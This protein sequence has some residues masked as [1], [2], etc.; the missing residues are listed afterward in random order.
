MVSRRCVVVFSVALS[1]ET[2]KMLLLVLAKAPAFSRR[3]GSF[4][5]ARNGEGFFPRF[6][7]SFLRV[8]RPDGALDAAVGMAL[9]QAVGIHDA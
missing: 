9:E 5:R 2:V 4:A 6:G 1:P 7:L 3:Q 8:V